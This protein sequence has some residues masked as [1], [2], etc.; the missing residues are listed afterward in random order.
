MCRSNSVSPHKIT[1]DVAGGDTVAP[2]HGDIS[3][4]IVFTVQA[5]SGMKEGYDFGGWYYGE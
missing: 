3:T 2:I 5:Y 1:Y 4:G